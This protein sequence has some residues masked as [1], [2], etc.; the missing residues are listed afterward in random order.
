MQ[1]ANRKTGRRDRA[2]GA[3][4]CTRAVRTVLCLHLAFCILNYS[5]T[6]AQLLDRVVARVGTVAITQ[7]DV[8]AATG[9]GLVDAADPVQ[10]MIDRQLLLLEVARFSPPE[11]PDAAVAAQIAAMRARAG[12]R[13][14]ALM[15]ATGLDDQR[16]RELARDTLR[17]ESYLDQRFG[18][19]AQVSEAEARDYFESHRAEFARGGAEVRF[20]QV[21]AAARQRASAE[22]RRQ[23]IA[24]WLRDLRRRAEITVLPAR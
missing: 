7:T 10:Q 1:N 11:P 2:T 12:E 20:E 24:Q 5:V 4:A 23:A 14:P 19:S 13:L 17:I 3:T 21:E 6:Q 9:L 16:L 15:Q 18:V 22:R 8:E